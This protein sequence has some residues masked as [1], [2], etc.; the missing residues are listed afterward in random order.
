MVVSMSNIDIYK[1]INEK[2]KRFKS[3]NS[4]KKIFVGVVN[5][6]SSESEISELIGIKN[7]YEKMYYVLELDKENAK[8]AF[9]YG[10]MHTLVDTILFVNDYRNTQL[11]LQKLANEK[12]FVI[13]LL[14]LLNEKSTID[15]NAIIQEFSQNND[16]DQLL[17]VIEQLKSLNVLSEQSLLDDSFLSITSEGK[18]F[19]ERNINSEKQIKG[20]NSTDSFI[21]EVDFIEFLEIVSDE[22]RKSTPTSYDILIS[23]NKKNINFQKKSSVKNVLDKLIATRK[24]YLKDTFGIVFKKNGDKNNTQYS[25]PENEL[26]TEDSEIGLSYNNLEGVK[27][28]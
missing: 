28:V 6:D 13:P 4:L 26:S 8:K 2:D 3:I 9:D 21:S 20:N 15:I 22:L 12:E 14:S 23:C 19:L 1:T 10:M 27:N 5:D 11:K 18:S 16:T 24:N 7:Q 25:L 17:E